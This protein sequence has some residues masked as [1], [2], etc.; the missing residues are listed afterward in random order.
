[1]ARVVRGDDVAVVG[2]TA[3]RCGSAC[4]AGGRRRAPA[5]AAVG[6]RAAPARGR[7]TSPSCGYRGAAGPGAGPRG[8]RHRPLQH[9]HRLERVGALRRLAGLQVPQLPRRAVD[10]RLGEQRGDVGVVAEAARTRRA[11]RRRRRRS[12]ACNPRPASRPGE[13]G[14]Q[15]LDQR[16]LDRL[17]ASASAQC[18]APRRAWARGHR[19]G[20][21]LLARTRPSPCCSWGR[22][23]RRSPS[24]PSRTP[25]RLERPAGS[26]AAPPRG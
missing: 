11:S 4:A 1:M 14:A 17:A 26:S 8:R 23:R 7:A 9:L 12:R 10:Q 20:Q 24:A 18:R 13:R 25:G 15:R 3:R 19:V 21:L 6:R 2:R 16:L 5:R 22:S